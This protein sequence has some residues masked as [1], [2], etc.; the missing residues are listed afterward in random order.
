MIELASHGGSS[1]DVTVYGTRTGNHN[2]LPAEALRPMIEK[3]ISVVE[4][5][6]LG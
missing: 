2:A 4:V 1:G 6:D 5:E 3:N